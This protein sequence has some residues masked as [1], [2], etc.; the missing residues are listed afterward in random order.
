MSNSIIDL[1][2]KY[3]NTTNLNIYGILD[4]NNILHYEK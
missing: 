1:F 4:C 3:I 2:Y